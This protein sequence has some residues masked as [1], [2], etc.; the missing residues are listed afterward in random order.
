MNKILYTILVISFFYGTGAIAQDPDTLTVISAVKINPV[1]FLPQEATLDTSLFENHFYNPAFKNNTSVTF[2]GNAG[3]AFINNNFFER[4]E[5]RNFIFHSAFFNYFHNPENILHYNTRKPFTELKYISSGG[6]ATSEQIL[7]TLHTQNIDQY[8]NAGIQYDAISSR[9]IYTNQD[10]R[11]NSLSIFGSYDNNNYSAYASFHNN[12]Q[13]YKENGGLRSIDDFIEHLINDPLGYSMNLTDASSVVKKT[14]FFLAQT[15]KNSKDSADSISSPAFLPKGAGIHHVFNYSRYFR[16]YFDN[17]P[18]SDTVNF[19]SNN[20]YRI[21]S[22]ND[23][24]FMHILENSVRLSIRDSKEKIILM[25]GVKHQFQGFSLLH[26]YWT[27]IHESDIDTD[28]IIG[29]I[30]RKSYNNLA[31]TGNIVINTPKFKTD[32]N[33]EY[34]L[35]GFRQHDLSTNILINKGFGENGAVIG[36]GGSFNLYEPDFFLKNYSSSHFIWSNDF[37]KTLNSN[38]FLYIKSNN[39]MIYADMKTG[40]LNNYIYFNESAVPEMKDENIYI[41]AF[42]LK[43]IFRWGAFNHRHDILIQKSSDDRVVSLPL[44]AYKNS[45][46]YAQSFFH[47]AL[48]REVGLDLYFN[49]PYYSDTYMPALGVFHRQN[50]MK[51]GNYPLMNGFF[52]WTVKRTRFF[53]KYTNILAGVSGYNYFTSYGYP[54]NEGSLKFGIA[55]TFYD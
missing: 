29:A 13:S 18:E 44:V 12:K 37:N 22:A 34:F 5:Y 1:T 19:Y 48:T 23:S 14:T 33:A 28:T 39:G 35:T 21:N 43:K 26:P 2:L 38:V 47:K 36:L 27:I 50:L 41:S 30:S 53:L 9:G 6:R 46:Y 25:T 31:L 42:T 40:L 15:F 45:T 20:F 3:Q 17:I 49:N 52:N 16:T 4:S 7:N 11:A 8:S 10:S 32:I 54:L 24:A 51:T 55:W